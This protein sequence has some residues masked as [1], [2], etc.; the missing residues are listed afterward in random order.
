MTFGDY[1]LSGDRHIT[2][3]ISNWIGLYY[4]SH[5]GIPIMLKRTNNID[6]FN[7]Q[8]TKTI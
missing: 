5:V 8:E 1:G 7:I 2:I 6:T 3:I 4:L